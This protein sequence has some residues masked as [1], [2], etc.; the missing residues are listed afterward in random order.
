MQ[1]CFPLLSEIAA[2]SGVRDGHRNRKSQKSLRFRCAKE[3]G[4]GKVLNIACTP[5]IHL[6]FVVIATGDLAIDVSRHT[7][8]LVG[9]SATRTIRFEIITFQIRKPLN[10]VAVIAE[11]S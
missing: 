5:K 3:V 7:G 1:H 2:I 4:S 8:T 9:R 11:N 10:H 6:I